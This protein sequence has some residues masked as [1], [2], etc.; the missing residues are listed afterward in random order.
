MWHNRSFTFCTE[1]IRSE[2]FCQ[3]PLVLISRNG[4]R[5]KNFLSRTLE[6]SQRIRGMSLLFCYLFYST[7]RL[8]FFLFYRFLSYRAK[9]LLVNLVN[10]ASVW[11]DLISRTRFSNKRLFENNLL[12]VYVIIFSSCC[13]HNLSRVLIDKQV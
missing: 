12:L 3:N 6:S 7:W 9:I 8:Y 5:M 2:I 4:R 13:V 1:E 10:F 11:L